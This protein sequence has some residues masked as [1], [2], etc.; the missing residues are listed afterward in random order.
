MIRLG[1]ALCLAGW[2]GC[3]RKG[4]AAGTTDCRKDLAELTV[5]NGFV[6]NKATGE[7]FSGQ[8]RDLHRMASHGRKSISG[9]PTPWSSVGG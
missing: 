4:V 3:D 9:R 2:L 6:I 8:L 7:L 5:Q 1:C